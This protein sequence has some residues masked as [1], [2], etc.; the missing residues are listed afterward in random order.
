MNS[1][2]IKKLFSAGPYLHIEA[3]TTLHATAGPSRGIRSGYFGRAD[4]FVSGADTVFSRPADKR[5]VD[6]SSTFSLYFKNSN[7]GLP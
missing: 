6:N 4:A 3:G 1:R 7:L 5:L 2:F